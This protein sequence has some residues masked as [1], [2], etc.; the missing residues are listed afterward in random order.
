MAAILT[1]V[2]GARLIRRPGP[3]A[4]RAIVNAAD[5]FFSAW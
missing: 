1:A 5:L 3:I 2:R 4:G